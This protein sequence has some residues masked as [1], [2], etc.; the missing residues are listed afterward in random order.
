MRPPTC[1]SPALV[2]PS[3]DLAAQTG[4]MLIDNPSMR[5]N[6][7][8]QRF[9][10]GDGNTQV[11][12]PSRLLSR[13][14]SS[15]EAFA[16]KAPSRSA[17]D[18]GQFCAASAVG[19]SQMQLMC[20]SSAQTH[21]GQGDED[22]EWSTDVANILP[23]TVTEDMLRLRT[24]PV[25]AF[26]TENVPLPNGSVRTGSS[27]PMLPMVSGAYLSMTGYSW[28]TSRSEPAPVARLHSAH[29]AG[30]GLSSAPAAFLPALMI[31]PQQGQHLPCQSS[32]QSLASGGSAME[33]LAL[34]TAAIA[35]LL[36]GMAAN[37]SQAHPQSASDLILAASASLQAFAR[38]AQST[39]APLSGQQGLGRAGTA[40]NQSIPGLG[41]LPE[42]QRQQLAF[43]QQQWQL[44]RQQ[45]HGWFGTNGA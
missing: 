37:S 8:C 31:H 28:D 20:D 39:Q 33:Q 2:S 45:Q 32:G 3:T 23:G 19:P 44:Q 24:S 21:S 43:M 13:Q 29:G 18:L 42:H 30:V 5:Y 40:A 38:A 36:A 6:S 26:Q 1:E 17:A 4:A 12:V 34:S 10:S 41:H 25:P 35:D 27:I 15:T 22:Q 11:L 7:P 14:H 16:S 9:Q